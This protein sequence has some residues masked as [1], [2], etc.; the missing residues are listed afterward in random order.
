M[1]EEE[2]LKHFLTSEIINNNKNNNNNQKKVLNKVKKYFLNRLEAKKWW[3]YCFREDI[4]ICTNMTL[5]RFHGII[6]EKFP[7]NS[8]PRVDDLIWILLKEFQRST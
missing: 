4:S 8:Y 5:E 2:K 7:A 3:P 1:L 6:K